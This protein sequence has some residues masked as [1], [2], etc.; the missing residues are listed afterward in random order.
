[1]AEDKQ[2]PTT[3]SLSYRRM[4]PKWRKMETLLGGTDTMRE[5]G[6]LYAPRH[7]YESQKNYDA[8]I[9]A[10]TLLNM[11][12]QTL[13]ALSGKPFSDPVVVS[14]DTPELICNT[15]IQDVDLQGN[16]ID[17]FSRSWFR[18]GVA[19]AFAHVLVDSPKPI[20]RADGQP[21]TLEDD[22]IDGI[23]PYMDAH[24]LPSFQSMILR[25]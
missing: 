9:N 4:K 25:R 11:V 10:T 23:R 22:R 8:R 21:R 6:V 14:E 16:N 12:E 19:K 1:M 7:E 5:A 17:V 18:E 13:D 15:I 24:V 3:T 2:D 20:E